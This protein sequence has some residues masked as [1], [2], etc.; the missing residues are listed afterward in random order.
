MIG[1]F[2]YIVIVPRDK[3]WNYIDI[4]KWLRENA[5]QDYYIVNFSDA[6]FAFKTGPMATAFK[7]TFI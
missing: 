4:V 5:N 1:E 6:K 7:L 2:P 3:K